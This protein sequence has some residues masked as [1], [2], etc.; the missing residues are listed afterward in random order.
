[1]R[2]TRTAIVKLDIH[3]KHHDTLKSTFKAFQQ[4]C[5]LHVDHAWNNRDEN[6]HIN[7]TKTH[8]HE[9]IYDEVKQKTGLNTGLIQ[10]AR[11]YVVDSLEGVISKWKKGEKASK[12]RFSSWF[13]AYDNRTITYTDNGC[14]LA[15]TNGRIKAEFILPED[16]NNPQTEY[17]AEDSEWEK[18]EATLHHRNDNDEYYLHVTVTKSK[19]VGLDEDSE[20]KTEN[21][22]V[23][24][25]DLNVRGSFAVTSTGYFVESA[26]Y[27]NHIRNEYEKKRGKM[28]QTGT[29]SAHLT[30]KN[31]GSRFSEWSGH[32]L[33]RMANDLLDEAEDHDVN[34]IVFEGLDGIRDRMSNGKDFQQWAFNEFYRVLKYKAEERGIDVEQVDPEYTSKKCSRQDC[35]HVHEDN[36]D[37]KKFKCVECGYE[38]N[39]DYNASKNI[40]MKY[41][42]E[43]DLHDVHKSC[44]G[45]AIC[46]LALKLGMLS[47]SE[48]YASTGFVLS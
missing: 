22:K 1:M 23:L 32:L 18:G 10:K 15:T 42:V 45:G 11:D 30:M 17:L 29:R 3:Q 2:L 27:L 41:I 16:D 44:R 24:G 12:P 28:Q 5:Q 38:V 14:S 21:G 39:A 37:G 43:N 26:D 7:T 35:G 46:H 33:H 13:V 31:V 47:V 36:R 6:D 4:A 9:Q 48:A 19:E 34:V 20:G 25:V 40:A 8:L